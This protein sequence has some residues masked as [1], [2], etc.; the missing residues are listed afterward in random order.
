MSVFLP[1]LPIHMLK[2]QSPKV[3]ALV[4]GTFERC[5]VMRVGPSYIGLVPYK[6][7]CGESPNFFYHVSYQE[8]SET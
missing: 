5:I 1:N 7:G 2:S 6:R 4:R 8:K 3:M